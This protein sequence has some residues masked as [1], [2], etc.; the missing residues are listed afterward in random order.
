MT[1][2]RN[3]IRLAGVGAVTASI[4]FKTMANSLPG[5][6]PV[7]SKE[8]F[9]LGVA[10]YS[11][12]GY[13]GDID[14]DIE[15]LKAVNIKFV[16]LKD[17][18]LPYNC[19]KEQAD[20][21]MGKFRAAGIEPYGLGV[22]DMSNEKDVDMAIAYAQ[23]AGVKMI[24]GAPRANVIQYLESKIKG[25]DIRVAIHNHGP[26]DKT[27]PDIDSIYEKIKNMDKKMGICLDIGHSF[28]CGHN[29]SEMLLKYHDRI[30]DMHFK[31]VDEPVK[32]GK[33]VVNGWGK[34]DFIGYIKALRKIKYSGKIS[35]EFELKNPD[36]GVAES[37]GHFRGVMYA[38]K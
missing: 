2:R 35:L 8:L 32:E 24:I 25:T 37:L 13:N 1:S 11:F 34:M 28:R 5:S 38:T 20:Q 33:T 23:R 22:I 7:Q 18:Q 29:P 36:M 9:E 10:G 6:A 27:F 21:V 14:K 12:F 16:T 3:F 26:E 31:D 30:Y 17:F 15:I 4:P 19:T